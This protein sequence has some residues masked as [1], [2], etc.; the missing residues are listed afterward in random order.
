M[1]TPPFDLVLLFVFFIY[2][3]A[4]FTLGMTLAV[5]GGRFQALASAKLL[6]P[7]AI[8]GLLHGMH[9]WIDAYLLQSEALKVVLPGWL[10]WFRLLL[11]ATSF[12]FLLI[13]DFQAFRL[14]ARKLHL[15]DYLVPSVV[16]IFL[17]IILFNAV[18]ALPRV[19]WYGL[20]SVLARYI[21]A[22]P[23]AIFAAFSL[24]GQALHSEGAERKHLVTHLTIAAVGFGIYGFAQI[25]VTKI[26]MFPASI[27][28]AT[29]FREWTGFPIQVVR[30][31]AA[32]MI[33][34][35]MVRSTQLAERERQRQIQA[36]QKAHLA[37]IEERDMYRHELLLHTVKAQEDERSRIA[38]ELHDE[39]SQILTA[40][41][42]NLATLRKKV[43]RNKETS[44]LVDQLQLLCKQTSLSLYRLVH[45]L[46]PAELDDL[47]LIP[48]IQY[49]RDSSVDKGMEVSLQVHG[50]RRRLDPIVETVLF[51]VV[52]EALNNVVR[53]AGTDKAQIRVDFCTDEIVLK[54][55][56]KGVGFDPAKPLVPP[57]GWGLAGMRER[58][59][60]IGGHL[61]IESSDGM[62]T[63]VEVVVP[64]ESAPGKEKEDQ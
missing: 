15:I 13:F 16:G 57:H 52:Q 41:S 36:T 3:L 17:L 63:T 29:A 24:R 56:D 23:G 64:D 55:I 22:V 7:L 37:A 59:N 12:L 2:G 32:I 62:G 44:G 14:F 42:L 61:I 49:L 9:E 48:A 50:P 39:T 54:I 33:T 19:G 11:L 53:H 51:R 38:R 8:F 46:R 45:D 58:I 40:F 21:L 30:T 43:S 31:F 4:F 10:P 34:M 28:N 5:E 47:G 18:E 20:L 60:L 26:D 35:G 25:F 1:S 6:R 27:I